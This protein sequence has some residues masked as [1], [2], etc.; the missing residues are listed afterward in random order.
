MPKPKSRPPKEVDRM[1]EVE[2]L[3]KH[4]ADLQGEIQQRDRKI[5]E[6][7]A[8]LRIKAEIIRKQVVMMGE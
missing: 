6:L 1:N 3:L 7:E 4:I 2:K 8:E 5:E